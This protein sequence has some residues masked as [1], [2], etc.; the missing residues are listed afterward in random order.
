MNQVKS[1]RF[2]TREGRGG[3]PPGENVKQTSHHACGLSGEQ[4]ECPYVAASRKRSATMRA[5]EANGEVLRQRETG[6]V[7][8]RTS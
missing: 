6:H 2:G 7:R 1:F 5:L 8:G 4:G 3:I